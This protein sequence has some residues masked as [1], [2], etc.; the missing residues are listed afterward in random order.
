VILL[1]VANLGFV[2]VAATAVQAVIHPG[3]FDRITSK[4]DEKCEQ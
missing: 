2:V 3:S 1:E 4:N